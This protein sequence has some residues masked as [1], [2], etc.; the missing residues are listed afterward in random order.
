MKIIYLK[1]KNF[2]NIISGM[3]KSEIEIDFSKSKNKL[4]VLSGKN[5]SGKTSILSELH[6]F[7]SCGNMDVRSD[8]CLIKEGCDGYKEIHIQDKEDIY[9]IKHHY[10]FKNKN[11]SVKSYI[12]KNGKELNDNGNVKSFKEQVY[13]NLGIDQ[14]LLKLMRLGSNVTSL[15][16]MKAT[17]RKSFATKLFSDMDI[18]DSFY[19]KV[20]NEYRNIRAVMKNISEKI[21]QYNVSDISDFN[22]EIRIIIDRIQ[23]NEYDKNKL[24]KEIAINE[25]KLKGLVCSDY[26][27]V[28]EKYNHL[29]NV[30]MSS[31]NKLLLVKDISETEKEYKLISERNISKIDNMIQQNESKIDKEISEK[32]IYYEQIQELEDK[33]K[34]AVSVTRLQNI[35][36]SIKEYDTQITMLEKKLKDRTRYD[37][38]ELMRVNENIRL[39][40]QAYKSLNIYKTKNVRFIAKM[41][42]N[43]KDV[44]K[45]LLKYKNN[46]EMDLEKL[47][48]ESTKSKFINKLFDDEKINFKCNKECPY[49]LFYNKVMDE[50]DEYANIDDKIIDLKKQLSEYE[51][52]F[53]IYRVL[54]NIEEMV[55]S[56]VINND[57]PIDYNIELILNNIITNKPLVNSSKLNLAI[58]DAESFE[59]LDKYRENKE[60]IINEYRTIKDFGLDNI[61]IEN[62][63]IK[64]KENISKNDIN[65]KKY[66]DNINELKKQKD[67][68]LNKDNDILQALNLREQLDSIK[69][70]FT[71]VEYRLKEIKNNIELK[72]QLE[73]SNKQLNLALAKI[74]SNIQLDNKHKEELDYKLKEYSKLTNEYQALNLLFKDINEIRDALNASTGIPLV[75]LNVY[76]KNCPILMNT[77]LESVFDGQLQID[78]FIINENEFRIPFITKGILVPDIINASQGES[79][80]ISIVLSLSLIIQSMTSYDIICLDELDGPLDSKN[81]QEF[82][83][84]LYKFIEQV[85]CEQVFLITHNNMFDNEPVD[86]I[87]TSETDVDNFK[88]GNII[89]K[90]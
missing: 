54:L 6:P 68:L 59:M 15:I 73:H 19:K 20:S 42:L 7:S 39:V 4:I 27:E 14:D 47:N 28:F 82:I 50:L 38:N 26:D 43:N 9:V 31:E 49:M 60:K 88:Y 24:I 57:I 84:I 65:I 72:E 71:E 41:M 83:N 12:S 33:L 81:R 22:N 74:N 13:L 32:D 10:L 25:T 75:Y 44:K 77:L 8:V 48:N 23:L 90:K 21:A 35:E 17:N 30:I 3:K 62:K 80:F 78:S 29:N 70:E 37:K 16:N 63:I 55:N 61:T 64:I 85:N 52:L 40:I 51:E 45:E 18:Y 67:E 46:I 1:L 76:L 36:N 69:K 2:V 79:S 11:K 58:D 34:T 89:F 5:G 87:L 56:L 66:Q 53:D 86:L